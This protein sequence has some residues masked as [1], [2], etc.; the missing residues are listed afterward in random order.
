MNSFLRQFEQSQ[1]YSGIVL[2]KTTI[3]ICQPQKLPEFLHVSG[4]RVIDYSRPVFLLDLVP[5]HQPTRCY[6]SN[7]L[8]VEQNDT[9]CMVFSSNTRRAGHAQLTS[10]LNPLENFAKCT[11]HST[12]NYVIEWWYSTILTHNS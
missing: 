3:I 6:P 8:W 2:D 10:I 1:C 7:T 9:Y 4:N 12:L 11:C 5:L